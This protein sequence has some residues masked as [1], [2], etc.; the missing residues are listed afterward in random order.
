[1]SRV[2]LL[3]IAGD[4]FLLSVG[5]KVLWGIWLDQDIGVGDVG[6]GMIS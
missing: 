1:M 5:V 3:A 4:R 6:A 2:V